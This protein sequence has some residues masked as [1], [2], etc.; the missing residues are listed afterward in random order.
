MKYCADLELKKATKLE[1]KKSFTELA[2]I[3]SVKN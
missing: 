3:K 1:P 2:M